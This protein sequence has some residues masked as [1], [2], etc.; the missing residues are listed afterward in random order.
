MTR[1]QSANQQEKQ[2]PEQMNLTTTAPCQSQE[3]SLAGTRPSWLLA[4]AIM[5]ACL[6]TLA[7]AWAGTGAPLTSIQSSNVYWNCPTRTPRP[8]VTPIPT[9]CVEVTGTPNAAGTPGPV[10]LLCEDPFSTATPWPTVTPYGRWMS[11]EDRGS[12]NTFYLGQDVRVGNLKLTLQSYKRSEVIPGTGGQVAHIFTF[13]VHNEGSE[14]LDVQ[15]P[16]QMFVREV[17]HEGTVTAGNWWETWRSEQAA[18]IPRWDPAMGEL[19]AGQQNRVTVAIEGPKGQAHAV[20]FSPDPTGG[21]RREELANSAHVL[22]FVP[23]YDGYCPG[24]NTSGP[25]IRGD[26]GA[27]YPKPLPST[28][29]AQYGYFDGWPVPKG[30]AQVH[31]T[32]AFGCTAFPELSG[33]DCP[34]DKPWFHSGIDLAAARGT[35]LLSV[36]EGIVTYVGPSSGTRQCTF[37]GAEPP[38]YNLGWMVQVRVLDATGHLG[39]YTVKYGHAI[40]GSEQV[41]VGDHVQPGQMLA[42]MGSTGC[43]TGPHLHFMVQDQTGR[44]VDPFNFIGSPRR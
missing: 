2:P 14:T 37:P 17:E 13:S 35:P 19:S 11:P 39:P 6:P 43:S 21:Q 8:T 41:Q 29:V 15:W 23:E 12:S 44:F 33:F 36:M 20:G 3:Q 32:Q 30:S 40:I 31:L 1:K 10:E 9:T 24:E 42:R 26:G 4:T 16:M 18:G 22:W 5:F 27:V 34:N 25:S 28:P 38:R 7:C